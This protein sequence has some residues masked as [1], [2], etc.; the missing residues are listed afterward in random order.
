MKHQQAVHIHPNSAL[1]EDRP[2]WLIYFELVF[3]TKE[4]MRQVILNDIAL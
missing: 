2:R 4:F 1:H 3:T